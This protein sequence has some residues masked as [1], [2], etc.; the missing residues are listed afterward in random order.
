LKEAFDRAAKA[1][2]KWRTFSIPQMLALGTK[3]PIAAL[4]QAIKAKDDP[5]PFATAYEQLTKPATSV[6]AA[7][8]VA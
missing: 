5:G 7:P 1:R 2:P 4:D 6:T 8:I 3:V